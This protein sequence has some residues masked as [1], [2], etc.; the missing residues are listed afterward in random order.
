MKFPF[1]ALY[2]LF[3]QVVLGTESAGVEVLVANVQIENSTGLKKKHTYV[4]QLQEQINE[5]VALSDAKK[6]W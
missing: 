4:V 5:F 3:S 2:D 1:H 6:N